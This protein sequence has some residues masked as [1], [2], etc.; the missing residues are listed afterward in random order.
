MECFPFSDLRIFSLYIYMYIYTIQYNTIHNFA[1]RKVPEQG[2]FFG[3]SNPEQSGK[4]KTP[5]AHTCLIKTDPPPPPPPRE[6]TTRILGLREARVDKCIAWRW[7]YVCLKKWL[8]TARSCQ[9]LPPKNG[10]LHFCCSPV[11][12]RLLS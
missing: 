11:K 2:T 10:F 1:L 4:F 5:V 3:F 8:K 7:Y 9:C 6:M 12:V